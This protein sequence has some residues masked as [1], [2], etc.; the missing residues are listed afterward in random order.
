MAAEKK[1]TRWLME[2]QALMLQMQALMCPNPPINV[3]YDHARISAMVASCNED[4][5]LS[6][7]S[8]RGV[9]EASLN[10]D[11]KR[12]ICIDPSPGSFRDGEEDQRIHRKPDFPTVVHAKIARPEVAGRCALILHHSNPGCHVWDVSAIRDLAPSSVVLSFE[13]T[14]SAGSSQ[15]LNW[16]AKIDALHVKFMPALS[17]EEKKARASL[18][19]FVSRDEQNK[20]V[21]LSLDWTIVTDDCR[22]LFRPAPSGPMMWRSVLLKKGWPAQ[23]HRV[24]HSFTQL[25]SPTVSIST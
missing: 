19:Q 3:C 10:L 21:D 2:M 11:E 24:Q 6:V 17:E 14:G 25:E 12:L 8:G 4:F 5:V 20:L 7:G 15:L 1:E 23:D 16:M 13:Q 22:Y 18:I 9:L